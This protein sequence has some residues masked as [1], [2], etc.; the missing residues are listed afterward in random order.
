MNA[1]E[2]FVAEDDP[3]S[4]SGMPYCDGRRFPWARR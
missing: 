3:A 4:P 1:G 2:R